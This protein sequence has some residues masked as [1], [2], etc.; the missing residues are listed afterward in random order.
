MDNFRLLWNWIGFSSP[1]DQ[2]QIPDVELFRF[3]YRLKTMVCK[4]SIHNRNWRGNIVRW[5]LPPDETPIVGVHI[6]L[7][8]RY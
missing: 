5:L 3:A 4:Q 2:G 7:N 6:S 8:D 1:N